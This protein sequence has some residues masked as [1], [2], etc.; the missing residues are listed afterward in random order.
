DR[1]WE[2]Y[3]RVLLRTDAVECLEVSQLD[4]AWTLCDDFCCFSQSSRSLL[5]SLRCYDLRSSFPGRF[6]LCS[7]RPLQLHWQSHVFHLRNEH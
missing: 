6:C 2:D 3:R 7:H 5:L 4:G 1:E